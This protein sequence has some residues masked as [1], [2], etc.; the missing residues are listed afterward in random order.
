MILTK[1]KT[2]N[3]EQFLKGLEKE[4]IEPIVVD[5]KFPYNYNDNKGL[6]AT[7]HNGITFYFFFNDD[8]VMLERSIVKQRITNGN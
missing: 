4:N 5:A 6:E 2:M 8:G 1:G 3:K 7:N